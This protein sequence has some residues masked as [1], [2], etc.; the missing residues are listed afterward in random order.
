M[1]ASE[2][3]KERVKAW[4]AAHPERSRAI[5]KKYRDTHPTPK[6]PRVL[7]TF[8]EKKRRAVARVAAWRLANP[9]KYAAQLAKHINKPR[10]PQQKARHTEH[11]VLRY[12]RAERA[13]P[14]WVSQEEIDCVYAEAQYM[15]MDVDHIVPLT[16]KTVSGLHVPWNMQLLYR[17]ENARK[18]NRH[19]C[20]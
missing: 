6:H 17:R 2:R 18:G 1:R 7:L 12:H 4:V 14:A 15:Q 3:D 8:E 19:A 10:T 5:K 9:E 20:E 16:N 13:K 11:Q